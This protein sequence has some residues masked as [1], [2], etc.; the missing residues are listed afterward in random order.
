MKH[1]YGLWVRGHEPNIGKLVSKCIRGMRT[2]GVEI[3]PD[4]FGR[5]LFEVSYIY[6]PPILPGDRDYIH[7]MEDSEFTA[8]KLVWEGNERET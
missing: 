1:S 4:K 8:V 3:P 7:G 6:R 5:T 2:G